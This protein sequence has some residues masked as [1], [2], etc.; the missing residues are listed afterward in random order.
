MAPES[1]VV[2]SFTV[3]ADA[4]LAQHALTASGIRSFIRNE[5][6]QDEAA[7]PIELRVALQDAER[8]RSIL[9]PLVAG[10]RTKAH[11]GESLPCPECG[12]RSTSI[13]WKP[14]A[15]TFKR[16]LAWFAHDLQRA[17]LRCGACGHEWSMPW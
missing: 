15:E 6:L 11:E 1:L 4:H 12:Q 13:T 10:L 14:P 8:A 17:E 9:E 5:Y 7:P 3:L 16:V 2:G